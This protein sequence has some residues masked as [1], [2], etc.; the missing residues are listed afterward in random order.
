[1]ELLYLSHRI[2]YP[3][4]KGDKIRSFNLL[5]RLA[6]KW[7]V[8]LGAFIDDK[9][10]WQYTETLDNIFEE[11]RFVGLSPLAAKGKAL[12]G[13]ITGSSLTVPYYKSAEMRAWISH[14]LAS[15]PID[16]VLAFSSSMA[17]Y[18]YLAEDHDVRRVVDFCDVDSE[19]WRQYA[20]SFNGAKR[21]IYSREARKLCREEESFGQQ[22]D[23]AIFVSNEESSLYCQQTG[24][25]RNKV[26]CVR[27]GVDTDYF[28][29]ELAMPNPFPG[30][31]QNIVFVG[32]MDY[33]PNI[34]AARWFTEEIMPQIRASGVAA[35]FWIVGSKPSRD[36]V[37][38]AENTDIIVTGRVDDVRPFL[39]FAN[40]TVAPLR[41]ARG[42]QNKVLEALAMARPICASSAALEGLTFGEECGISVC[43]TTSDWVEA[44]SSHIGDDAGLT[45]FDC[46]RR[47]V[48]AAY[49]WDASARDLAAIVTD[50][51][52][53]RPHAPESGPRSV[54]S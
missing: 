53:S 30:S 52:P 3:P 9:D 14:I 4:N 13:L 8:H 51:V 47:T 17:Q 31:G 5:Q 24:V 7:T 27:N 43:D 26:H 1:M 23:A 19:K 25:D 6:K 50:H 20:D 34:D 54:E 45:N 46:A 42:V 29:P 36:I 44:L 12:S 2:P 28:D 22:S 15:R 41:V 35:R 21:W 18:L 39:K 40:C 49:S 37:A 32:A 48:R 33:W 10:D 38:L 11:T 16:C